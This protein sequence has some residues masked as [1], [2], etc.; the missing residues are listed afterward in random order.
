[1]E[2]RKSRFLYETAIFQNAMLTFSRSGDSQYRNSEV[3]IDKT[4]NGEAN[5]AVAERN[6]IINWCLDKP[7][8]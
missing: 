3:L 8:W 4:G 5:M 6:I 1:M 2:L 7:E